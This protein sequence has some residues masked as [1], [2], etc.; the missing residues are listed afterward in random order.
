[1]RHGA[2]HQPAR[3]RNAI[4]PRG[5]DALPAAVTAVRETGTLDYARP[6]AQAEA[7]AASAALTAFP[8]SNYRDYLLQLADFAVNREY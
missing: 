8:N 6:Q 3:V 7:R 2:P 5:R 1:M 4:A